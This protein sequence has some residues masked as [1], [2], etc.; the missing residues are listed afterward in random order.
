MSQ[1]HARVTGPGPFR[2]DQLRPEDRYELSDGHPIYCAPA[3]ER[4]SA[5]NT[6]GA[7]ILD[8]DPAAAPAGVDTGYVWNEGRNLR[9]ADVSV[10]NV[11]G[12]PGWAT[13]APPLAVEYADRG[14]D[15]KEL[16]AKIGELLAQGTRY[17]W[18]VR[19]Q[20]PLRVE[21]HEPGKPMRLLNGDEEL[22]APGI[23]QNPV[24]VRALVDRDA[25][26]EATLRN[27]LNRKGY[28]SLEAIEAGAVRDLVRGPGHR[29]LPAAPRPS[30]AGVPARAA[31]A[32]RPSQAP[33]RLAGVAQEMD[34]GHLR[35]IRAADR[36]VCPA[37]P[38]VRPADRPP[39]TARRLPR[40]A[41]P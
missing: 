2:A 26:N 32:A 17:I 9:A 10:G 6:K 19:L 39:R 22:T 34:A 4:H 40:T 16:E 36:L 23:L 24:P 38:L 27:L 1:R 5:S 28:E 31:G 30:R 20:G 29:A 7:K 13:T 33:P 41:N 37:E 35:F 12:E 21:V 3:S 25:A 18:V 8:T 15:E 14:Q 11:H